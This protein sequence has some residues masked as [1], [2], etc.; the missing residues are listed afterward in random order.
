MSEKTAAA[1]II[2]STAVHKRFRDLVTAL[3]AADLNRAPAAGE[4][5]IAV[6]AKHAL[7]AERFLLFGAVDRSIARV[8]DEEFK[9]QMTKDELLK[10]LDQADRDVAEIVPLGIDRPKKEDATR[11]PSELIVHAVVHCAEHLA[12]AELTRSLLAK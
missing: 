4:N 1:L 10:L 2:E 11:S 6:L 9:G 12:Q 8:R 3:D 5:S 7:G